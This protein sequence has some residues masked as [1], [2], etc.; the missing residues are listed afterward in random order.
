MTFSEKLWHVL[1]L[2][3]CKTLMVVILEMSHLHLATEDS[4]SDSERPFW[5][6]LI[7]FFFFQ[8]CPLYWSTPRTRSNGGFNILRGICGEK[9]HWDHSSNM[10]CNPKGHSSLVL[11]GMCRSGIWQ[12]THTNTNFS[13]KSDPFNMPIGPI[14]RQI[15]NKITRF[16]KRFLW[17]KFRKILKNRPIH[18]QNF[19]FYKGSFMYKKADFAAHVGGTSP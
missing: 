10:I 7:F 9:Q 19:A 18:I 6:I 2:K 12:Q 3:P 11:V 8:T 1:Y 16:F 5:D 13:R 15:L 14:F 4:L 17:L